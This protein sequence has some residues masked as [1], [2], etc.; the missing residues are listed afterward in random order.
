MKKILL[1]SKEWAPLNKTGLGYASS[2]HAKIFAEN[3]NK[4]VTV[5]IQNTELDHK[6]QI[7]NIFNFLINY[8]FFLKKIDSILE[9]EKPDFVVIET[10]QTLI[11]ELFILRAKKKKFK[12]ILISHG[13][14]IFPYQKEIKYFLRSLIWMPYI[15][16]LNHIISKIDFFF[17]L[18]K[19]KNYSRNYDTFVAKKYKKEILTYNNFSRFEN[20]ET[21]FDNELNKKKIILCLGYINHIKNQISLVDVAK[22]IKDLNIEIRIVYNNY[23]KKYLKKLKKKINSNN[24]TNIKFIQESDTNIGFEIS[25]SWL[26]I[27]LSVTEM[28]PLSLIEGLSLKKPFIAL[29]NG[30]IYKFK[31]GIINYSIKQIIFNIRSSYFNNFFISK[32]NKISLNDYNESFS[33]KNCKKSFLKINSL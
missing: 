29:D 17:S 1:I 4:V 14:S 26:L 24:L 13:I 33:K 12:V 10:L 31:G 30:G 7:K 15:F 18:D 8:N 6:I 27:N 19:N 20:T 11:S 21:T 16:L 25:N 28:S 5:G 23:D 9:N 2:E 3:G 22:E 32:L